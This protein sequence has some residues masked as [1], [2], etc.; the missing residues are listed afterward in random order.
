MRAMVF[1]LG[2]DHGFQRL[3]RKF[4]GAQH[5]GFRIL[6]TRMA[7]SKQI[8]ALAEENSLEAVAEAGATASTV[9]AIAREH[10]LPHRYCDPESEERS[11]LGIRQENAIRIAAFFQR[12]EE[13]EIQAQIDEAMRAR[14]RVWLER[15]L[16][17]NQWPVLF[18]CGAKHSLPFIELLKERNV[19]AVLVA[20]DWSA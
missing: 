17:W 3:D 5:N 8:A 9:E 19:E 18:V 10:G 7:E 16:E 1:V 14:E 12:I 4:S 11:R 20:E 15:L 13:P 2:T 6:L